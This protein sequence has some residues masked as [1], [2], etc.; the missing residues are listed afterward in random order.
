MVCGSSGRGGFPEG[1]QRL[2]AKSRPCERGF[3]LLELLVVI[4]ILGLLAALVGP[5]LFSVLGATREKLARQQISNLAS[6]LDLYKLDIGRYPD[7]AEGLAALLNRPSGAAAWNGP[8]LNTAGLPKD[9]WNHDFVYRAPSHRPSANY[10]LCSGG[11]SD[12][13]ATAFSQ[14]ICNE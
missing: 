10:D 11:D 5:R 8:Y 9:P 7:D 6:A 2:E 13:A 12:K 3:T 14:A 4:V 1:A